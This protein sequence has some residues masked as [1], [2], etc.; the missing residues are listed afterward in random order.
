LFNICQIGHEWSRS[1]Y[2]KV[3]LDY[4]SKLFLSAFAYRVG[5]EIKLDNGR[6]IFDASTYSECHRH[7]HTW[8]QHGCNAYVQSR[9][10]KVAPGILHFNGKGSQKDKMFQVAKYMRW[11]NISTL[12]TYQIQDVDKGISLSLYEQCSG[13]EENPFCGE[14]VNECLA[15]YVG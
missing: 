10:P 5:E 15:K 12:K 1:K 7:H 14:S 9:P 4:Y 6:V 3:T 11:P 2:S 13:L 8:F